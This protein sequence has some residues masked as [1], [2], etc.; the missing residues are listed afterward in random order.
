LLTV[1]VGLG[2]SDESRGFAAEA[3]KCLTYAQGANLFGQSLI[4]R[5]KLSRGHCRHGGIRDAEADL[6]LG[7]R[8][9]DFGQVQQEFSGRKRAVTS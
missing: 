6:G 1:P 8:G 3:D 5:F 7:V 9:Y 4:R 2:H